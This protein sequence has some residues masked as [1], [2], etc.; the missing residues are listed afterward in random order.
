MPSP[1]IMQEHADLQINSFPVAGAKIFCFVDQ[2]SLAVGK[3]QS[4]SCFHGCGTVSA[5]CALGRVCAL[6]HP[7]LCPRHL[8]SGPGKSQVWKGKRENVL[9]CLAPGCSCSGLVNTGQGTC[10]HPVTL[11]K[12]RC[13]WVVLG[14]QMLLS[15]SALNYGIDSKLK[16]TRFPE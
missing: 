9:P 15:V 7:G 13:L 11:Y 10:S 16:C 2:W 8:H 6:W 12:W 4:V 5:V 3:A 14:G 1:G